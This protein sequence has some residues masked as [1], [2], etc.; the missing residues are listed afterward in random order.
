MRIF[1]MKEY[2]RDYLLALLLDIKHGENIISYEGICDQR[3]KDGV[4]LK[5]V[6]EEVFK[7]SINTWFRREL[8]DWEH[9][10]GSSAFPVRG[11][12]NTNYVLSFQKAYLENTMWEGEYGRRRIE[13]LD[14]II[15]YVEN[16]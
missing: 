12:E 5:Y 6:W 4:P 15:N 7:K 13:L 14:M 1:D 16:N 3:S 2:N 9:F 10:S 8:Q 11:V